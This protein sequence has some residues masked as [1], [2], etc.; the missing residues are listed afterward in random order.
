MENE[1]QIQEQLERKEKWCMTCG[2]KVDL[3]KKGASMMSEHFMLVCGLKNR[4]YW[5]VCSQKCYEGR[6]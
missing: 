6:K 2:G 5:Y 3:R 4:D 1:T